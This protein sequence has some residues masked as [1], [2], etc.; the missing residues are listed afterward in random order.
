[1]TFTAPVIGL[2][3]GGILHH[4]HP[5]LTE[6]AGFPGSRAGLTLVLFWFD[7]APIGYA[8]RYIM[9]LHRKNSLQ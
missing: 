6:L 2:V 1:M 9:H 4:A 8:K 7:D 5:D 3:T